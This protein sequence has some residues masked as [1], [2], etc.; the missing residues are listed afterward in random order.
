MTKQISELGVAQVAAQE[1]ISELEERKLQLASL[2]SSLEET[3]EN[4]LKRSRD[5]SNALQDELRLKQDALKGP[6][7]VRSRL[8]E[9]TVA[10]NSMRETISNL[11]AERSTLCSLALSHLQKKRE[12]E[13]QSVKLQS[14]RSDWQWK[15]DR[16]KHV[17]DLQQG[18]L[19][20]CLR[21]SEASTGQVETL[22]ATV[23]S[24]KRLAQ[25]RQRDAKFGLDDLTNMTRENQVLSEELM[26][27]KRRFDR[28][29]AGSEE[30]E[31]LALPFAQRIQGAEM[32][33]DHVRDVYKRAI[34]EQQRNAMAIVQLRGRLEQDQAELESVS[35]NLVQAQAR[36]M[37]N[38]SC[39]LDKATQLKTLRARISGTTLSLES[40]AQS[41]EDSAAVRACMQQMAGANQAA[42]SAAYVGDAAA[43]AELDTLRIEV[44]TLELELQQAQERFATARRDIEQAREQQQHVL[45]DMILPQRFA[46]QRVEEENAL[47]RKNLEERRN[48]SVAGG[49]VSERSPQSFSPS[50]LQS[51]L[52]E[53]RALVEVM[54]AE[55]RGLKEEVQ[56]LQQMLAKQAESQHA[57]QA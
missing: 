14:V 23:E 20:E 38:N 6:Q 10:S 26:Q 47:L 15:I 24:A 46:Q 39:L 48:S 25:E 3:R 12:R 29:L 2:L 49:E 55:G 7:D 19:D 52:E 13:D 45:Q 27:V 17:R 44:Q 43:D 1:S 16:L 56:E 9:I 5:F 36:E 37:D 53:Q 35:S 11:D 21:E 31:A 50:A 57:V 42:L 22:E 54:S 4:L 8:A 40:F 41:Q 30:Q 18:A 34:E 32:E 28:L 33:R 51:T